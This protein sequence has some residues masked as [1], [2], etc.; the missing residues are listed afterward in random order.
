MGFLVE[1]TYLSPFG[2]KGRQAAASRRRHFVFHS[3]SKDQSNQNGPRHT[4]H[5]DASALW[6]FMLPRA[7]F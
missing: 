3:A 7:N 1:T 6:T 4:G 5:T 2:N